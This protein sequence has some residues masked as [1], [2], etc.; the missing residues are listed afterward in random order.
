VD[1]NALHELTPAYALDALEDVDARAYE[2]HLAHC[3]RCQA[4]LPVLSASAGALGFAVTPAEPP[5]ALRERILATARAERSNVLPFRTR[6][7]AHGLR[8]RYTARAIAVAAS[9][10]A[11][12][13]GIW[14]VTLHQRLDRSDQALRSV[15]LNGAAGSVV[16]GA[17][18]QGTMVLANL[19]PAPAG[20][21]YEAWV[22]LDG[23]AEPAG[24]FTA[25]RETIVVH[26]TRPVPRGAIVAVTIEPPGGSPQPTSQPF[27]TSSEA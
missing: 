26:L 18:G 2:R 11:V 10:A 15:L 27:I 9:V 19:A 6:R 21:T 20:K 25:D 22:I 12:G 7:Q 16:L 24:V 8:G 14:N 13:L 17:E 1:D 23:K 5:P 3:A 4:E